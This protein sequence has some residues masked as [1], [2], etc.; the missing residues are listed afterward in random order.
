MRCHA[1]YLLKDQLMAADAPIFSRVG[2][3][4]D[5]ILNRAGKTG[6][7][8]KTV[9]ALGS[10]GLRITRRCAATLSVCGTLPMQCRRVRL[11]TLVRESLEDQSSECGDSEAVHRVIE[12]SN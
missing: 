8:D 5:E 9:A 7:F 2:S 4:S 10:D 11:I 12:R 1:P 3:N 6:E